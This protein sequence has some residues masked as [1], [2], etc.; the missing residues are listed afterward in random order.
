[1]RCEKGAGMSHAKIFRA[2]EALQWRPVSIPEIAMVA[3]MTLDST[4]LL[5]HNLRDFGLVKNAG[6][7]KSVGPIQPQLFRWKVTP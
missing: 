3:E 4:R 2:I 6:Y 1:M 7:G 5:V